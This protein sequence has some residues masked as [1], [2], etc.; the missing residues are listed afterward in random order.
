MPGKYGLVPRLRH[1]LPN[2]AVLPKGITPY[3]EED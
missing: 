1:Q 2:N 3:K